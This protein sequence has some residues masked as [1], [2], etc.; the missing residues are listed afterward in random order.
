MFPL[1]DSE[2][3]L[4]IHQMYYYAQITMNSFQL[5]GNFR[6]TSWSSYD[7]FLWRADANG[8][9]WMARNYLETASW[10][11]GPLQ[12]EHMGTGRDHR[13]AE[14]CGRMGEYNDSKHC[15]FGSTDLGEE[16]LDVCD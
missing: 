7:G 4:K 8:S 6:G 9:K 10:Q 16:V 1:L 3:A 13:E 2:D 12:W 14:G 5:F 15:I 11:G